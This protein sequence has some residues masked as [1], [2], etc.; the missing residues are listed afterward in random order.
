MTTG[1]A[2]GAI[3]LLL[4]RNDWTA[5]IVDD[6]TFEAPISGESGSWTMV[7]G[8]LPAGMRPYIGVYSLLEIEVPDDRMAAMTEAVNLANVGT[9]NVTF[10]LDEDAT[11]RARSSIRV[12]DVL[13][14]LGMEHLADAIDDLVA[15]QVIAVEAFQPALI[16]VAGGVA[17]DAAMATVGR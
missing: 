11:V 9:L 1:Q 10:E 7:F 2:V 8:V 3:G 4:S 17:P 14:D 5:G 6:T 15:D 13:T 16:A 12:A